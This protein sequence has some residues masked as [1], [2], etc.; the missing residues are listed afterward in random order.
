M[1]NPIEVLLG[2]LLWC[3]VLWDGFATVVLPTTVDPKRRLSANVVRWTWRQ[4]SWVGRKISA[5]R[6]RL[7]FLAVYGPLSIVALLVLWGGLM[8]VAFALI[9]H[10]LAPRFQAPPGKTG[11]GTLLYMSGSTFLTLGLGDVTASD[12][13]GRSVVLLEAASGYMFLALIITFVPVLDQSYGDREIGNVLIH[14]RAGTPPNA[15]RFLRRYAGAD[16]GEVLRANLRDGER[17]MATMLESHLSHPVLAYY[18]AQRPGQS[19]LLSLAT[20]L[21]ASALL[22][23]GGDGLATAQ[24]KLTFRMGLRLLEELTTALGITIDSRC[25]ARLTEPELPAVLDAVMAAKLN[26]V[27]GPE[28]GTELLR[29]VQRYDCYLATLGAWLVIPLP[30]WIVCMEC[31]DPDEIDLF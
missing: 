16:Y 6:L 3:S 27:L 31:G 24:A 21:D 1:I 8:I 18:R 11:F 30:A 22:I 25:P 10:G 23:V 7:N 9:Y 2:L 14:S 17:W 5:P 19:W 28:R 15:I 13:V 4:W 20:I 12:P 29:L 26:L